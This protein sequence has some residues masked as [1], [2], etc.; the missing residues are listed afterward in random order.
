V[1]PVR[2]LRR[3]RALLSNRRLLIPGLEPPAHPVWTETVGG[4][5]GP[6]LEQQAVLLGGAGAPRPLDLG[7]CLRDD[8]VAVQVWLVAASSR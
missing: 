4:P 3:P 7:Q 1:L 5:S 8:I 6:G 2:R